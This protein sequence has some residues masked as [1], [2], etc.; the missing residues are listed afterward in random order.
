M[1]VRVLWRMV[2]AN[3]QMTLEY[4][5]AFVVYML[6]TVLAPV[7]SLLVWLTV[8]EQG[9]GLPFSRGQLVTYYLLLSVVSMLTATWL[10]DYLAQ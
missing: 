9:V 3:V 1:T 4:R 7:I 10:G 8:S 2:A 6:S 5:G